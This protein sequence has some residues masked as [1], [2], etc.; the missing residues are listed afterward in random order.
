M[1]LKSDIPG[2]NALADLKTFV[3]FTT[4]SRMPTNANAQK[5]IAFTDIGIMAKVPK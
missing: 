3:F 5:K 1:R 2:S 4:P